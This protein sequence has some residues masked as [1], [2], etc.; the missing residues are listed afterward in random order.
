MELVGIVAKRRLDN[1]VVVLWSLHDLV[2]EGL[3]SEHGA[4]RGADR[5]RQQDSIHD[6]ADE[7]RHGCGEQ[8]EKHSV[9]GEVSNDVM[10]MKM[11]M[12]KQKGSQVS[13]G[14]VQRGNG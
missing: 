8:K 11:K 7:E 1:G 4:Q 14:V 6:H 2:S 12:R 9:K 10:K 5:D 3:Y 13:V